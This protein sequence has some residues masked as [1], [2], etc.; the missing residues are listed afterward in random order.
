MTAGARPRPGRI[1]A[2]ADAGRL[3]VDRLPAAVA[4]MADAGIETIQLRAKRLDDDALCRLAEATL[5]A[6]A[7][8]GGELWI[9][10]R[11]DLAAALPFD[12]VHLGRSDLPPA[13][14]R[15]LLAAGVGIGASTHDRA[16]LEEAAADPTV[17]WIALGP[18]FPT[19]SKEAPDPV[20]GLAELTAL[21][22]RT[23]KPLI[24]IGGI[25]VDRV[26]ATLAAGADSVAVI[27]AIGVDD[28]AADCRR[29]IA[30]AGGT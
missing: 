19:S 7:G 11:V 16:Q 23:T 12:G 1:Y 8:W 20:V 18:I 13:A 21:R 5:A 9:D 2:I 22:E 3:P 28:P 4:A 10:D 30:A 26:A 27:S 24:A 15:P 25:S 29:L 17:D 6:V 14:A